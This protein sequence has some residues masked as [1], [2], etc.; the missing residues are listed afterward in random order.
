MSYV[1]QG[2]TKGRFYAIIGVAVLHALLGFA[3]VTGLAGNFVK[4]VSEDLTVVNV[5]EEPPPPEEE[6]PPPEPETNTPP[7]VV[8]PPPLVR[9]NVLP[10]PQITVQREAPPPRITPDP[11]RQEPPKAAPPPVRTVPPQR[12]RA[13]LASY[14]S[15]D[16]YPAAAIRAEASGVTRFRLTIGTNG[17]VTDCQV[18]GSSGNSALDQATCRILR[19]RARYTPARDASGNPTTGTDS[20]SVT[21]RLPEE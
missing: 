3:F 8:A 13:S 1:D 4:K 7:P 10:P 12:A 11:P 2:M 14:F 5:E 16:D 18:T 20:A 15:N 6:P 17:R 9:T 21:W 19:S